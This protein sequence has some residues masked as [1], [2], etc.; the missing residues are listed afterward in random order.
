MKSN[1]SF[2]YINN[3]PASKE[4]PTE[5]PEGSIIYKYSAA[6]AQG[7]QPLDS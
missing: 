3:A 1:E 7:P 6:Y 2:I 5:I 4:F